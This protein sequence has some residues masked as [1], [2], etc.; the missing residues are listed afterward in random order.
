M[1]RSDLPLLAAWLAEPHVER[2]WRESAAPA[3][4]E[5]TYGPALDGEP[6]GMLQRYLLADNRAYLNALVPGGATEAS[7]SID[8]MIGV[9]GLTGRG[10]G[11]ALI[12]MLSD[13]TWA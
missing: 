8:Y 12:R 5:A 1:S 13:S 2:W 10:L 11:P 6:V 4:V 9:A 3:D 7:V